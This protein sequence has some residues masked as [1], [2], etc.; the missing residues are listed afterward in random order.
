M[1]DPFQPMLNN[2]QVQLDGNNGEKVIKWKDYIKDIL[3]SY[4]AQ[5][6]RSYLHPTLC[7]T[8]EDLVGFMKNAAF[9]KDKPAYN[10]AHRHYSEWVR[11]AVMCDV[12]AQGAPHRRDLVAFVEQEI[13]PSVQ[14]AVRPGQAGDQVAWDTAK[15]HVGADGKSV[16]DGRPS[17]YITRMNRIRESLGTD[18]HTAAQALLHMIL[19]LPDVLQH[20]LIKLERTFL[21]ADRNTIQLQ[22]FMDKADELFD[23]ALNEL[24]LPPTVKG[25]FERETSNTRITLLPPPIKA[26]SSRVAAVHTTPTTIVAASTAKPAAS[27]P[28]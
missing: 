1:G 10:Y 20:E 21:S 13:F 19:G 16:D 3:A 18:R 27:T 22:T 9:V 8:F 25:T 11:K 24:H 5:E 14:N 17:S 2:P 12:E 28:V 26:Q 6:R 23:I 4:K 15:M 7:L